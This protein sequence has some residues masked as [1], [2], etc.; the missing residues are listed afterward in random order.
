MSVVTITDGGGD[1]DKR[2]GTIDGSGVCGIGIPLCVGRS[3]YPSW[4]SPKRSARQR[5][6]DERRVDFRGASAQKPIRLGV[7]EQRED[8][9]G[10]WDSGGVG[11][12]HQPYSDLRFSPRACLDRQAGF[13]AARPAA[14]LMR[15]QTGLTVVVHDGTLLTGALNGEL[16]QATD[17]QGIAQA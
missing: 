14:D 4:R 7:E 2:G 10:V 9:A 3:G 6:P 8:P 13:T 17:F 1:H 12:D 5:T 16:S 15:W 11:L